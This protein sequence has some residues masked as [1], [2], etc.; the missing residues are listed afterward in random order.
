MKN[1]ENFGKQISEERGNL[2]FL[3][4]ADLPFNPQRVFFVSCVPPGELRGE[5]AHYECEQML[6]CVSG[7]I[8]VT[9][10]TG[11]ERV[12][13]VLRKGD[14]LFHGKMEWAE[15]KYYDNG[16]MLSLCSREYDVKDYIVS[17]DEFL[18]EVNKN[19]K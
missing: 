7:K 8:V 18:R 16:E 4:L 13:H 3:N 2:Y 12:E 9:L 19:E 14:T 17:Y 11:N 15:L 6:V 10:D 1:S 5:H